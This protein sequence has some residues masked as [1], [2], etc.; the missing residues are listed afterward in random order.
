MC[1]TGNTND[2]QVDIYLGWY[3]AELTV[4]NLTYCIEGEHKQPT[5]KEEMIKHVKSIYTYDEFIN[6]ILE[7]IDNGSDE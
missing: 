5:T 4:K 7:C 1:G 6:K 3:G 2:G